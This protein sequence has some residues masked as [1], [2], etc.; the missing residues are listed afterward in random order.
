MDDTEKTPT[1]GLQIYK[2]TKKIES[3]SYNLSFFFFFFAKSY[4]LS[5]IEKVDIPYKIHSE[6]AKAAL[7]YG[8]DN[9]GSN[10]S[11]QHPA[12]TCSL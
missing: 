8:V 4:N 10:R 3:P 6:K 7:G 5:F 9:R 2:V 12:D 1:P 11:Q